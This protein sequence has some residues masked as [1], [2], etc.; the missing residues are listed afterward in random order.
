MPGKGTKG[1]RH[2]GTKG[3]PLQV[4]IAGPAERTLWLMLSESEKRILTKMFG[5]DAFPSWIVR[6]FRRGTLRVPDSEAA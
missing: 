3:G 5:G 1:Q 4:S 6:P 2:R